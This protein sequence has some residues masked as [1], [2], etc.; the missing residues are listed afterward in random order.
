MKIT[1]VYGGESKDCLP[2]ITFFFFFSPEGEKIT[3]KKTCSSTLFVQSENGRLFTA[4]SVNVAVLTNDRRRLW[5]RT[6]VFVVRFK[7]ML[8]DR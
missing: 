8:H 2:E 7:K 5:T 4:A 1:F 3:R 6:S